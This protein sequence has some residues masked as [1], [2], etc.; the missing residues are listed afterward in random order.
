[1]FLQKGVGVRLIETVYVDD[2]VCVCGC[3][4]QQSWSF[5][6]FLKVRQP[7]LQLMIMNWMWSWTLTS[8]YHHFIEFM[9]LSLNKW[10]NKRTKHLTRCEIEFL[11]QS[12]R[13]CPPATT[14]ENRATTELSF[15][16]EKNAADGERTKKSVEFSRE[17]WWPVGRRQMPCFFYLLKLGSHN[18]WWCWWLRFDPKSSIV[19][20]FHQ[21]KVWISR[22]LPL[23]PSNPSNPSN[24]K[25]GAEAFFVDCLSLGS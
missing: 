7:D 13:K 1:M 10:A 8:S 19:P 12:H 16:R 20:R 11:V 3:L 9:F 21:S 6:Q 25:P 5:L 4:S 22:I 24:P 23:R 18:S 15:E 14:E 2:W 17:F